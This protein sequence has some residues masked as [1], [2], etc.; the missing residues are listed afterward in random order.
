ME[1]KNLKEEINRIKSLFTEERLYGNLNNK[2]LLTE[3]F[4]PERLFKYLFKYID[5]F[6]GE[7]LKK[8]LKGKNNLDYNT[9]KE[10]IDDQKAL[11][12]LVAALNKSGVSGMSGTIK[13]VL[14]DIASKKDLKWLFEKTSG[15]FNYTNLP[16]DLRYNL[17]SDT[18]KDMFSKGWANG[19]LD[20]YY[21]TLKDLF[22]DGKTIT[23]IDDLDGSIDRNFISSIPN[24]ANNELVES[25]NTH[26]EN[27]I[28]NEIKNIDSNKLKNKIDELPIGQEKSM[29]NALAKGTKQI[30]DL[31]SQ[32]GKELD[33]IIQEN[34]GVIIPG[35]KFKELIGRPRGDADFLNPTSWWR[36]KYPKLEETLESSGLYKYT[37]NDTI[38]G[39]NKEEVIS[40]ILKTFG[41]V[42]NKTLRNDIKEWLYEFFTPA[43]L[44]KQGIQIKT[45][46]EFLHA[47]K[48]YLTEILAWIIKFPIKVLTYGFTHFIEQLVLT[49]KSYNKL[50]KI[51]QKEI[52][53]Y[54]ED[55]KLFE[56]FFNIVD[57]S[58]IWRE[59]IKLVLRGT[60]LFTGWIM[61]YILGKV[62]ALNRET[63]GV[64]IFGGFAGASI[65]LSKLFADPVVYVMTELERLGWGFTNDF[66][67]AIDLF[68]HPEKKEIEEIKVDGEFIPQLRYDFNN[69]VAKKQNEIIDTLEEKQE[70]IENQLNQI[71]IDICGEV[72]INYN[73]YFD[74]NGE[75]KDTGLQ[76]IIEEYKD[77]IIKIYLDFLQKN[78]KLDE[79]VGE[80]IKK[81]DKTN[82]SIVSRLDDFKKQNQNIYKFAEQ[83]VNKIISNLSKNN[84]TFK[85][86]IKTVIQGIVE[87][88]KFKTKKG[89]TINIPKPKPPKA[90]DVNPMWGQSE[91]VIDENKISL[92]KLFM[93]RYNK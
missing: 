80:F 55:S 78:V 74:L 67:A 22:L 83:N 86:K 52:Y 59:R 69:F 35:E 26:L 23:K 87:K 24:D 66:F 4:I 39:V 32:L 3:S 73:N 30:D 28:K 70:E 17:I 33:K 62:N 82:K 9:F 77:K 68:L 1:N 13:K 63:E 20:E 14:N 58:P 8:F 71:K 44:K 10:I 56:I 12:E 45:K 57:V 49:I 41:D 65:E 7:T 85:E 38:I 60:N 21:K 93:E 75:L 54:A 25:F 6:S 79:F 72:N 50:K 84:E 53:D 29:K 18:L 76:Y 47:I 81:Y 43:N 64:Y 48:N 15:K 88:C 40:N 36:K 2:K 27:L 31:V 5:E 37:L 34:G 91:M 46:E 42:K 51:K 90:R 89:G 11:N 92:L 61:Y 19:N 16:I